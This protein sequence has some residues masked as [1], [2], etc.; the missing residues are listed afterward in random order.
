MD[1]GNRRHSPAVTG[2]LNGARVHVAGGSGPR[3]Q[4]I[5]E[6]AMT[7]QEATKHGLDA[8]AGATVVVT[9]LDYLPDIAAALSIIWFL[10][11]IWESD[12]V[13]RLFEGN[14]KD[15]EQ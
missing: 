7:I 12:T 3:S 9:W 2:L 8:A 11:R 1:R 6:D 14:S 15:R 4:F 5:M 10:I 13:R